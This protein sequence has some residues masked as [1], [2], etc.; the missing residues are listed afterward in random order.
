[1]DRSLCPIYNFPHSQGS[2]KCLVFSGLA[3]PSLVVGSWLFSGWKCDTLNI[4]FGQHPT[5][6][7]VC[8]CSVWYVGGGT[9]FILTL[10]GVFGRLHGSSYLLVAVT[11]VFKDSGEEFEFLC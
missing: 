10:G 1:M 5:E 7:A 9:R 2:C 11:V 6:A 8:R 4:V 3:H